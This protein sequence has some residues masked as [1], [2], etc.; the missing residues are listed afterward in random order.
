MKTSVQTPTGKHPEYKYLTFQLNEGTGY[1]ELVRGEM[2]FNKVPTELKLEPVQ[3]KGII[4]SDF[5]IR[6]RI[7]EGKYFFFTGLLSTRL[8]NWYFGDYY[9][10]ING[11]K[12]NSFI[13]FH[14]SQDQTRFEMFF[15]NHFKLYPGR[16]GAFIRGFITTRPKQ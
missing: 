14:F 8:E 5:L 2:G 3:K 15:F 4:H 9:E 16:R 10:I 13:L 12:K 7:K 11:T 6:S 1:F